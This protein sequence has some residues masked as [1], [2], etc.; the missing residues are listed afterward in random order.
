MEYR[1]LVPPP[2]RHR[3]ALF[4]LIAAIVLA[5]VVGGAYVL[6][7]HVATPSTRP[8]ARAGATATTRINSQIGAFSNRPETPCNSFSTSG[9]TG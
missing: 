4:L 6:G 3:T 5:A 2:R 8:G 7:R 9:E 1:I